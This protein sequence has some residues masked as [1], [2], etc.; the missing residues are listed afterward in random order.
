VFDIHRKPNHHLA[1]GQGIHFCLGAP[2]ARLEANI[3]LTSLLQRVDHL[4]WQP[5]RRPVPIGNS[6]TI[7]GLKKLPVSVKWS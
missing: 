6:A 5:D 3:A 2:L 7:Y 1:F 4:S